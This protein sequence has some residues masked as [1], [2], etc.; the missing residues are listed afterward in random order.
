MR[1][2][3]ATIALLLGAGCAPTP[4]CD[5][6][7]ASEVNAWLTWRV[8]LDRRANAGERVAIEQ[9]IREEWAGSGESEAW[10]FTIVWRESNFL[11]WARNPSGASGLFQMMLPL[12]ANRFRAVG[13]DPAR[14]AEA[15]CNAA[16]A[17]HLY[18]EAGRLPWVMT[19]YASSVAVPAWK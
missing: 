3:A 1:K 4:T 12:H 6:A 11:P 15:R 2:I 10:L 8:E 5:E 14:W 19:N 7:C 13:C 18:E 17:R 9:V 16:A